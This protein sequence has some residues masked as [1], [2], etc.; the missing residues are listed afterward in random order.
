TNELLLQNLMEGFYINFQKP[1]VQ[2]TNSLFSTQITDDLDV[3]F[4]QTDKFGITL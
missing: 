3:N 4:T 1:L 2:Q